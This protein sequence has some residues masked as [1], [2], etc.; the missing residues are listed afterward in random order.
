M[1]KPTLVFTY[2]FSAKPQRVFDVFTQPEHLN[3]WYTQNAKVDLQVGGTVSNGDGEEYSLTKV[4]VP[5]QLIFTYHHPKIDVETQVDLTF[6]PNGQPGGTRLRIVHKGLDPAK[7][8]ADASQWVSDRWT[9]MAVNLKR[10]LDRRGKLSFEQ[11]LS[12]RKPVYEQRT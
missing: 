7:V 2:D 4:V 1:S 8:S 3:K 5:R 12:I 10:Y 9:F 11:Y 6:D